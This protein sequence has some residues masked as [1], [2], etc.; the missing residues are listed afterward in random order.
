[1]TVETRKSLKS[2][3]ARPGVMHGSCKVHKA[4]VDNCPPFRPFLSS[5]NTPTYKIAKFLVLD[6]D[7][8]WT[9]FQTQT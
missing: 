9:K 4:S 5:L 7:S 2:K 3:G 8:D 6:S 1:M